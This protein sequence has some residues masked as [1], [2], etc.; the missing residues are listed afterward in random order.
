MQIMYYSYLLLT[1][2]MLFFSGNFLVGTVFTDK[3]PPFTL[4]MLRCIFGMLFLL[5]LAW[6][7]LHRNKTLLFKEWKP[8]IG[9]ALTGMV[10]FNSLLYLSVHFTSPINASIVD[11]S[12]P[13]V[14]ALLAYF[15]LNER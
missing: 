13:V 14:V 9:L 12:T 6:R 15:M 1:L 11:A 5:P 7:N 10:C 4:A 2:T 3:V 8:L